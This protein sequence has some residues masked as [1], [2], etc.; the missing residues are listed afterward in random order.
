ML[1]FLAA[2]VGDQPLALTPGLRS[3]LSRL[4]EEHESLLESATKVCWL[5][6]VYCLECAYMLVNHMH[7]AMGKLSTHLLLF[8][9]RLKGCLKRT[10]ED[11]PT[12]NGWPNSLTSWSRRK[13]C[14]FSR[15]QPL[16]SVA[17]C[18]CMCMCVSV[19]LCRRFQTWTRCW[20]KTQL[21]PLWLPRKRCN[22]TKILRA[23]KYM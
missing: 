20:R 22:V 15:T 13:R 6:H 14:L 12:L 2:G 7:M 8:H 16:L 17:N 1:F 4:I 23:L 21:L 5:T 9:A 10:I 3:H 18:L 19:T 11:W